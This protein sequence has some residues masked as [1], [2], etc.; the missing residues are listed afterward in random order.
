MNV[1]RNLLDGLPLYAA[2]ESG[3]T[4]LSSGVN[5][6]LNYARKWEAKS[7]TLVVISDG[8]SE[9]KIAVR[10]I[11]SSIADTIVIGVGDPMRP[12]MVSGHRSTQDTTS[13]SLWRLR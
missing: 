8:D 9:E 2:F 10:L 5:E 3:P 12:T 6:A 7:A 1:V 13:L 4:K 11:P